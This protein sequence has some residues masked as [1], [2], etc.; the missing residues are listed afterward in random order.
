MEEEQTGELDDLG[1]VRREDGQKGAQPSLLNEKLAFRSA[2]GTHPGRGNG[3]CKGLDAE[4]TCF[5]CLKKTKD[6]QDW[7][8]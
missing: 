7:S 1:S 3:L 5:L 6:E 8:Q 2:A 4:M